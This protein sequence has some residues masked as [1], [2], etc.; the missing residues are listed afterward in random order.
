MLINV[1]VGG[2]NLTAIMSLK[3]SSEGVISR[4]SGNRTVSALTLLLLTRRTQEVILESDHDFGIRYGL[5]FGVECC[6]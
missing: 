1:L 2:N 5:V 4:I 3:W 6:F